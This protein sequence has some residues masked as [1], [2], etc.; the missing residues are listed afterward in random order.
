MLFRSRAFLQSKFETLHA[1]T[2]SLPGTEEA[3]L[4]AAVT[5]VASLPMADEDAPPEIVDVKHISVDPNNC[6]LECELAWH[7]PARRVVLSASPRPV[8]RTP[9]AW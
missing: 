4:A 2:A 6:A 9:V 3:R 8:W 1:K 5:P 7:P